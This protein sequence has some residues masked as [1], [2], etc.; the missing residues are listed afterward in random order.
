MILD[1]L[2]NI[3]TVIFDIDGVLTNASVLV[4]ETGAELVQMSIKDGYA[5]KLTSS[6]G[7]QV[8][9]ISGA[10]RFSAVYRLKRLGV[11]KAWINVKDKLD[12]FK[13]YESK[14]LFSADTTLYMGDDNPDI[15]LMNYCT[16]SVA[17]A[18]ASVDVL[19]AAKIITSANGGQGAVREILEKMLRAK[20]LWQKHHGLDSLN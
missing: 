18:D 7:I 17:P 12:L 11:T 6:L 1:K 10:N 15:P 13:K 16:L 8:Y 2:V 4:T 20:G 5:I 19:N 3:K 14:G 9:V